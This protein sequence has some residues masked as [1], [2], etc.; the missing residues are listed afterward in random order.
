MGLDDGAL[1][2]HHFHTYPPIGPSPGL[3]FYEFGIGPE[4][5]TPRTIPRTPRPAFQIPHPAPPLVTNPQP[6]QQRNPPHERQSSLVGVGCK[7]CS[8]FPK[9]RDQRKKMERH[10]RTD[11]HRRRTKQDVVRRML[12]P[13]PNPDGVSLCGRKFGRRDNLGQHLRRDHGGLELAEC[14]PVRYE[15]EDADEVEMWDV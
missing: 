15:L 14:G 13:A 8:F 5:P 11:R 4:D 2:P 12:C 1:F 10:K 7:P 6:P 3:E 9:G